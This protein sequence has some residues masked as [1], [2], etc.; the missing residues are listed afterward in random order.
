M[1]LFATCSRFF[2]IPAASSRIFYTFAALKPSPMSISNTSPKSS[3]TFSTSGVVTLLVSLVILIA[4]GLLV[5]LFYLVSVFEYPGVDREMEVA[6]DMMTMFYIPFVVILLIVLAV[7]ILRRRFDFITVSDEGVTTKC[8]YPLKEKPEKVEK[9]IRFFPWEEIDRIG[10]TVSGEKEVPTCLV[11][12]TIDGFHFAISLEYFRW[13]RIKEQ[14]LRFED[15]ESF[16]D[17]EM[18]MESIT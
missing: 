6:D 3:K 8:A 11:I 12:H 14:I 5:G 9:Y 4:A 10:Y 13:K 16:G 18:F 2:N 7:R 15:C 17:H 1:A